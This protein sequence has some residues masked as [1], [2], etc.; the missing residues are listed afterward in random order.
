MPHS[1][2]DVVT[3]PSMAQRSALSPQQPKGA[4][5]PNPPPLAGEGRE[6]GRRKK[7]PRCRADLLPPEADAGQR[8][9]SDGDLFAATGLGKTAA[10]IGEGP[11]TSE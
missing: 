9:I 5:T 11:C 1:D 8:S 6:G 4:P 10:P 2:F 7:A 3:G